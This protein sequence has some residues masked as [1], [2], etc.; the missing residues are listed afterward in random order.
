M[1]DPAY[2]ALAAPS[3]AFDA[4]DLVELTASIHELALLIVHAPDG[5]NALPLAHAIAVMAERAEAAAGRL[6]DDLIYRELPPAYQTAC[7]TP[8]RLI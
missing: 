5:D 1:V 4:G 6:D 2:P 3:A 8:G 7:R